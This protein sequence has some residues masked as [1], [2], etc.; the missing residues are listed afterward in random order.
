MWGS[1]CGWP[2]GATLGGTGFHGASVD[3]HFVQYKESFMAQHYSDTC[4][5]QEKQLLKEMSESKKD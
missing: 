3:Q 4:E 1:R 5:S 2:L